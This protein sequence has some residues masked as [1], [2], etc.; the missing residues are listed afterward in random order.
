MSMTSCEIQQ[1]S[2]EIFSEKRISHSI[3]ILKWCQNIDLLGLVT[4]DNIFEVGIKS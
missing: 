2:F 1:D 3:K 4:D